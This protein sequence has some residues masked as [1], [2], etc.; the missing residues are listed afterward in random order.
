M[1]DLLYPDTIPQGSGS[2]FG[3]PAAPAPTTTSPAPPDASGGGGNKGHSG[4]KKGGL[5]GFLTSPLGEIL[6]PLIIGGLGAATGGLALPALF[7]ALG[8]DATL[9]A[10]LGG[11][12]AGGLE[13]GIVNKSPVSA[14]T[15]AIEGGGLGL[16]GAGLIGAIGGAGAAAP[17][18]AGTGA[19][20][21]G[22]APSG[23]AAAAPVL[24]SAAGADPLATALGSLG[25]QGAEGLTGVPGAGGSPA[26]SPL[27][28]AGGPAAADLTGAAG[29]G[30]T[31]SLGAGGGFP[32]NFDFEAAAGGGAPSGGGIGDML[33][34]VGSYLASHPNLALS[35][36]GPI[37]S[38]LSP[39]S[40]IPAMGKETATAK[41]L[42]NFAAGAIPAEQTGNLPAGAE[43]F[44]LNAQKDEE[45]RIR[46]E[47]ASLG[48]SG[49]TME[50]QDLSAASERAAAQRF[51]IASTVTSQGLTA[52]GAAGGE[53]A[54]I[55]NQQLAQDQRL[56]EAIA[57]FSTSLGFGQGLERVP[58]A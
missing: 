47:Y 22:A 45:A 36:I 38:L 13:Q 30:G 43:Q 7:P 54:N 29:T 48:L 49:S 51:Q 44:V 2:T 57:A 8:L 11:A 6:G 52:A 55:A 25:A 1:A 34:G 31:T 56:Q 4:G 40:N 19:A 18:A 20:A 10:G 39:K 3:T 23:A 15:G 24:T 26:L 12:L 50:A 42:K 17:A 21:A 35:A 53:F 33:G 28:S 9:G 41:M 46:G 5:G 16:G 37:A 27:F 14:L 32:L 58:T